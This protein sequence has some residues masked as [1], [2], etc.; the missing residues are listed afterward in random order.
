MP[1]PVTAST[2]L[3]PD[4][5]AIVSTDNFDDP[6]SGWS[7]SNLNTS[8]TTFAYQA[9]GYV[10]GS[11]TGT[12]DHFVYGPYRTAKQQLS[13]SVTATLTGA[14][15]G[16][17]V[18]VTCRRGTGATQTTYAM[19]VLNTGKYYVERYDGVPG[20]GSNP[21]IIKKGTSDAKPGSTPITVVG[22]CATLGGATTRLAMFVEGQEI[23]DVDDTAPIITGS[24][25]TGGFVMASGKT[26][27]SLTA[28]SWVERDLS[29]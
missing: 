13:M 23:A 8:A 4:R 6:H 17:G 21:V 3:T 15:S 12:M 14:P 2:E 19:V 25:W 20:T 11:L 27:S 28:T 29:K 24:G 18:G 10:V 5:G 22:M 26:P 16:A 7:N 9:G 1:G